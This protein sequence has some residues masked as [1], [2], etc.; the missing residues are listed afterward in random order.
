MKI[1]EQYKVQ[2]ALQ[3]AEHE[4]NHRYQKQGYKTYQNHKIGQYT[5]DLYAEKDGEKIAFEFK[6]RG[7]L[8]TKGLDGIRNYAKANG[9][10]FRVVIVNIPIDKH[11]TVEGIEQTLEQYFTNNMPNE[12]D[13]L[14]THTRIAEVE[15]AILTSINL[16]SIDNIEIEGKSE[17]I[18]DLCYDN[19]ENAN[20]PASFPF[21]FKGTWTFDNNN[22]L[23][24]DELSELNIDTSSYDGEN[25]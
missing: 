10:H 1:S 19:D 7:R 9:I 15:Q 22:V 2:A 23:Q 20:F 4:M 3:A 14:S 5:I 12:L 8:N 16:S 25:L 11:I 6:T 17:V 24:L 13:T 18:I 21:T